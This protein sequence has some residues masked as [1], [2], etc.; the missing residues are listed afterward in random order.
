VASGAGCG[1]ALVPASIP[2]A[3]LRA[4]DDKDALLNRAVQVAEEKLRSCGSELYSRFGVEAGNLRAITYAA[5]PRVLACRD[6]NTVALGKVGEPLIVLCTP[7]FWRKVEQ[8]E[9]AAYFSSTSTCIRADSHECRTAGS[10]TAFDHAIVGRPVQAIGLAV[11]GPPAA[12]RLAR[13]GCTGASAARIGRRPARSDAGVRNARVQLASDSGARLTNDPQTTVAVFRRVSPA[14]ARTAPPRGRSWRALRTR[15]HVVSRADTASGCS[16]RGGRL[17]EL[18]ARYANSGRRR[19][20]PVQ[21]DGVHSDVRRDL[22]PLHAR[23]LRRPFRVRG[24]NQPGTAAS[25][26]QHV[27]VQHARA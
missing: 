7:Q 17:R 21:R 22:R 6:M 11:T 24:A 9:E 12:A 25:N 5:G 3:P 8:D 4:A 14:T 18:S 2:A 19:R 13:A 27:A 26:A 1:A 23:G 10:T 20:P 15:A 16:R